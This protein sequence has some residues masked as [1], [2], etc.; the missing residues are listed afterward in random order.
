MFFNQGTLPCFD[1]EGRVLLE[2]PSKSC[3][4]HTSLSPLSIIIFIA[5]IIIIASVA[6][7]DTYIL[8]PFF[9]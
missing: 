7:R 1:L 4:T 8:V 2:T 5:L 6:L 9:M 3:L